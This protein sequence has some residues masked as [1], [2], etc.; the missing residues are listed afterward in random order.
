MPYVPAGAINMQLGKLNISHSVVE[1]NTAHRD[2]GAILARTHEQY[3]EA[4][5]T[6]WL[7]NV[8]LENNVAEASGGACGPTRLGHIMVV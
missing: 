5:S 2:G 7:L 1:G 3:P 4:S 6:L 8:R